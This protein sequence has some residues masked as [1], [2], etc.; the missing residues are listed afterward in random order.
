MIVNDRLTLQAADSPA[1]NQG[2]QATDTQ[3]K[4]GDVTHNCN[5]I[6][7]QI[8]YRTPGSTTPRRKDAVLVLSTRTAT[9]TP[10]VISWDGKLFQVPSKCS[11]IFPGEVNDNIDFE[12]ANGAVVDTGCGAILMGEYWYFGGKEDDKRQ[13]RSCDM[14]HTEVEYGGEP[15]FHACAIVC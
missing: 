5:F 6:T 2:W 15:K 4:T 8:V 3:C 1:Y 12:Y 11:K 14:I 9:N 13:V 10:M 7:G